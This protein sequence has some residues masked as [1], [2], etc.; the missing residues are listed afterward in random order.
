MKNYLRILILAIC[1][2]GFSQTKATH[3][4]GADIQ[5][6]FI[7]KDT[8]EV[9]ISAYKDCKGISMAALSLS[10][11]GIGCN[12]SG[13]YTMSQI[14]CKDATPVCPS[15][16]SKCNASSCNANGN[17]NGGNPNCTFAYG[18]EK[19][20]FKQIIVLKNTNCCKFRLEVTQNA[21]TA[22]ITTC[23]V[24]ENLYIFADIDR[25]LTPL[26]SSPIITNDPMSIVC[27][28]N[29]INM[30]MGAIDTIDNDYITYHLVPVLNAYN[31]SCAYTGS[32]TYDK[33]M[34]Y[35]GFT[36]VKK[37]NPS[38]CKGLLLDSATGD[39]FFKPMQQEVAQYAI[40]L[41]EWRKDT[42]GKLQMI[43]RTR[44]DMI[45]FVLTG[46]SNKP[47]VLPSK[48]ASV[49]AGDKICFDSVQTTDANATDTVL[50]TWNNGIPKGTFTSNFKSNNIKQYFNFCW[51]TD[52]SDARSVPYIFT[53]S[54]QDGACP[55]LG[56]ASRS[57]SISV[58]KK[59]DSTKIKYKITDLSC[60]TIKLEAS[61]DTGTQNT[62]IKYIWT[63]DSIQYNSKDTSIYNNKS[64]WHTVKVVVTGTC[65]SFSF[66]DSINV[67][68]H[69]QADIGNDTAICS[70]GQLVFKATSKYGTPPYKYQWYTNNMQKDTLDT[71][72]FN[73]KVSGKI[74]CTVTDASRCASTVTVNIILDSLSQFSLGP[75]QRKCSGDSI[76]L[77]APPNMSSYLWRNYN[78]GVTL[79]TNQYYKVD[80]DV[81]LQCIIA[82]N[83]A[84]KTADTIALVFTP[85]VTVDLGPDKYICSQATATLVAT[86]A[87]V[88]EWYINSKNVFNGDTF[89]YKPTVAQRVIAKGFVT[90]NNV[91]CEG[92]DSI[93]I[94]F[95]T[96]PAINIKDSTFVCVGDTAALA[97]SGNLGNKYNWNTG[98]TGSVL[99]TK[100]IGKYTV[101]AT[102]TNGCKSSKETRL[103]NFSQPSVY[104]TFSND[105]LYANTNQTVT[106]YTWYLDNQYN[107]TSLY[108]WQYLTKAG[109]YTVKIKDANGCTGNSVTYIVTKLHNFIQG[110]NY[111][112]EIK[113][114][115]NPSTGIYNIESPQ[116]IN[117]IMIYDLIG[118]KV[119][120]SSNNKN[121]IDLSSQPE[122]IYLL[123][124]NGNVWVKLS[125]L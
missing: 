108:P 85:T 113:V 110:P 30:N 3:M 54:A 93:Y 112:E 40:E 89:Y 27:S 12:Y 65:N 80:T 33:P 4:I 119:Y 114:Y 29:C 14:N 15:S 32:Y 25:C 117:D 103:F 77:N 123:Q 5:Y 31:S 26:N 18:I 109:A 46:C 84:C 99:Y 90:I 60:G 68:S 79:S 100:A 116:S 45:L 122:G 55:L 7:H 120:N 24:G 23:C 106:N 78:T 94:N 13:S 91:T 38:T 48:N 34:Y 104:L 87:G 37:Y 52:S 19:L 74:Q 102:D 73:V 92:I 107:S 9:I 121:I 56:M 51:Q 69:F 10:I 61:Y 6:R 70:P 50:V 96:N 58:G 41:R 71:L 81:V 76:V 59:L 16:C 118:R 17:P 63:V 111:I 72:A 44:R 64:G 39:F 83:N 95:F 53:V 35:D 115:P 86:G 82:N 28:G 57:Y 42:T 125:K 75:D 49:C 2:I 67:G 20:V 36:N 22:A 11:S 47:P 105:T 88:H 97:A 43:G 98:D 8:L 101:T 124:I 62:G 1:A 21:R 66:L